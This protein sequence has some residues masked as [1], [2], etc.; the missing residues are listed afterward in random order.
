MSWENILKRPFD[1]GASRE[2]ELENREQEKQKAL[3]LFS[4]MFGKHFDPELQKQIRNKP[5]ANNYRV[6]ISDPIMDYIKTLKGHGLS[7][8]EILDLIKNAYPGVQ[9]VRYDNS[10]LVLEM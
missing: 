3:D 8:N 2:L 9:Q 4:R 5:N 7:M 1:V 6:L 10:Y